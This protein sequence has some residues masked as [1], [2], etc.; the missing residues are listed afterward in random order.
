MEK[1]LGLPENNI[2]SN[3]TEDG[4]NECRSFRLQVV[5]PTSRFAYT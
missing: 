1:Y 2:F 3:D 5:S 4:Q